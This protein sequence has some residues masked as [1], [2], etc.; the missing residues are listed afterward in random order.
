MVDDPDSRQDALKH[1]RRATELNPGA[2][3][4]WDTLGWVQHQSG[5]HEAALASLETG[6]ELGQGI[7]E[8]Y[9]H[10]AQV[11]EAMGNADAA[12]QARQQARTT[13]KN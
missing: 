3:A 9:D 6:A 8:I 7:A 4:Y 10:L 11:H 2:A 1:A 13:G 5:D 12:A